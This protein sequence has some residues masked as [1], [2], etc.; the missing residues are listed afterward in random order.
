MFT[1]IV[2]PVAKVPPG[3]RVEGYVPATMK[4]VSC[5]FCVDLDVHKA[6]GGFNTQVFTLPKQAERRDIP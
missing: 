4:Q 1:P 2:V 3:Y 5:E 6:G